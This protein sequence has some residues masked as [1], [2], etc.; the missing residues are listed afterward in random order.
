MA[1][2]TLREKEAVLSAEESAFS[3]GTVC[4]YYDYG[5]RVGIIDS[6]DIADDG[7]LLVTVKPVG[8]GR[9]VTERIK[10]LKM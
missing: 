8:K 10:D 7:D 2:R 5:W 1:K 6:L 4:S 3:I 9:K